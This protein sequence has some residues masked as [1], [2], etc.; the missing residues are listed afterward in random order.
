MSCA[1]DKLWSTAV[2]AL[3]LSHTPN[4]KK[5]PSGGVVAGPVIA[6]LGILAALAFFLL[7][8]CRRHAPAHIEP[9]V[10]ATMDTT[11]SPTSAAP[12][13]SWASTTSPATTHHPDAKTYEIR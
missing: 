5:S 6:G 1:W 2:A 10:V 7:R 12:E 8:H 3:S 9:L 11:A 13:P 4:K